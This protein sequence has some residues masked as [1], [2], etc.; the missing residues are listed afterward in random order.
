MRSRVVVAALLASIAVGA[1]CSGTR[2]QVG[3]DASTSIDAPG[4]ADAAPPDA[5]TAFAVQYTDPD[6]GPFTG[7]TKTTIRGLGF[8][9]DDEV[10]IGGR[11]ALGVKRLDAKHLE[12][13]TPPGEPGAAAIEVRHTDGTTAMRA[14][15][16]TYEAIAIAPPSGSV[17]GSTY[18]TITGFGTDFGPGTLVTFDG[19]PATGVTID[20]A[21]QLTAYTPPGAPG[22]ANVVIVTAAHEYR[23]DRGYTYYSTG[24]P[25]AGGLS[26][27]PIAG[28]LNV[29]VI[30]AYTDDGVPGAFVAVGDPNTTAWK[31]TTDA[32][33]QITFSGPDLHGPVNVVAAPTGYEVATFDCFDATNLTIFVTPLVPPSGQ[34]PGGVGTSDGTIRGAILFGNTTGLG[35]PYWNLVPEPRTPTEI[36]RVYVTTAGTSVFSGPRLATTPIDYHYDP[37]QLAWPFE[38]QARPGALAV[39]AVAGLY[40]SAK[41][42]AGD[43]SQGFTPYAIGVARGVLVGPTEVVQGVDVVVNIPLDAAMRVELDDPPPIGTDPAGP[44]QRMVSAVVDLGG[45]GTIQFG[46]HGL[47]RPASGQ[48]PGSF[49][50]P[51][52]TTGLTIP[53][54]PSLVGAI[55]DGAYAFLAGAYTYGGSPM[56]GRVVRGVR[57]TG[58]PIHIAGF[59]GVPRASDPAPEMVA[60]SR[61]AIFAPEHETA[62]PTFHLHYLWD[63]AGNPVWRGISCGAETDVAL[64]DL[65]SIGV[66]WPPPDTRLYWTV[67]SIET[68]TADFN[69]Y[70]YRWNGSSY[71]S[72]YATDSAW[73]QFPA[74]P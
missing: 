55:G 2:A 10:R 6:H 17:A 70:T 68:R 35:S 15:G 63:E 38:I 27:G 21:E 11:L 73:V 46:A 28:A 62:A 25:F 23:A 69:Q 37:E 40:D 54:A 42:P 22:D 45:E 44:L 43:G 67:W 5:S 1:G 65:S 33:G 31:G 14:D 41:D 16:F 52:D 53:G 61:H 50:L 71:W 74:A 26:G 9:A 59:L 32:L 49:T 58:H 47:P 57:D 39:I 66:A 30:D 60:T 72:A 64:P 48:L 19:V 4:L 13:T 18:V 7:G 8:A 34:G 20:G 24:D 12:V 29:V 36:K 3:H 51:D 56:S